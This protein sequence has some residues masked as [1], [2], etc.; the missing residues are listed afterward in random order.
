MR[1]VDILSTNVKIEQKNN[2]KVIQTY[3]QPILEYGAVI[4]SNC[5]DESKRLERMQL[6]AARIA[7]GLKK[8][9]SHQE[10]YRATKWKW[11]KLEDRRNQR[12]LITLYK[13]QHNMTPEVLRD[14]LPPTVGEK[15]EYTLRE[16]MKLTS[17]NTTSRSYHES[18][19]PR[20]VREWN[21]LLSNIHCKRGDKFGTI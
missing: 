6:A 13:I 15:N 17:P 21:K 12:C 9:M 4:W 14:L 11:E 10:I 18:F 19:L 16:P 1:R 3:I 20:S 7:Y 2:G 8:G 5:T